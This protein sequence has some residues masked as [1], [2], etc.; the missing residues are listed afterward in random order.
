MTCYALSNSSCLLRLKEKWT[1]EKATLV[2]SMK[3]I[4]KLKLSLV[5]LIFDILV[6]PAK[7]ALRVYTVRE[8]EWKQIW[9][10]SIIKVNFTRFSCK[11]PEPKLILSF[12]VVLGP[13]VYCEL[14]QGR[15]LCSFV[16]RNRRLVPLYADQIS[17]RATFLTRKS[18]QWNYNSI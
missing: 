12:P 5:V 11:I 8:V 3:F 2:E 14:Q 7:V 10:N 9:S 1:L 4:D 16:H 15:K 6:R 18:K 13:A 17:S